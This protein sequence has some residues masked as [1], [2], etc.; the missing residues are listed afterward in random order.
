MKLTDFTISR[1][2]KFFADSYIPEEQLQLTPYLG[3]SQLVELFNKAGLRDIYEN[4]LPDKLSRPAYVSNR[5]KKLSGSP[6]LVLLIESLFDEKHF[7]KDYFKD[8]DKAA[9]EFNKL[10]QTDGYKIEKIDGKYKVI[11]ADP[12][13]EVKVEVY[14]EDIENKIIEEI[15]KAK[16]LIWVAVAWFTNK[17]IAKAL[18]EKK[19]QGLSVRLIVVDDDTNRTYGFEY[20]RF[21][22]TKRVKPEG[23]YENIMHHK[24]CIIDMNIV[25]RGTYNWTNKAN[26]NK[27][28]ISVDNG[29]EIAEQYASRFIELIK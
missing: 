13:E 23:K 21:Y 12:P 3:G 2:I 19:K 27:E 18:Y 28:D 14:F 8:I 22:E 7:S 24:F 26:W 25:V 29:K 5:L 20:E 1:I 17:K 6:E 9:I 10:I 16:Y 4:A 15:N 11:G